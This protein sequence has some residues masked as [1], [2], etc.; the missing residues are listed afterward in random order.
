MLHL[1]ERRAALPHEVQNLLR[2]SMEHV[3]MWKARGRFVFSV[4]HVG[5]IY[6]PRIWLMS[7][8]KCEYT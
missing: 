7:S 1:I 8:D 3:Q 4:I 5:Y 6:Y 2:M